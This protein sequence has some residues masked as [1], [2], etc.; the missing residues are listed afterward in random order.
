MCGRCGGEC[1]CLRK[2]V[3]GSVRGGVGKVCEGR[4]RGVRG[5]V[6]CV[7]CGYVGE[8]CGGVSGRAVQEAWEWCRGS[9]Q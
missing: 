4:W 7:G 8:V 2:G 1:D 9:G 5:G 3:G 6:G